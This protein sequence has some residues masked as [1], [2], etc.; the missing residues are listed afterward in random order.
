MVAYLAEVLPFMTLVDRGAVPSSLRSFV[1]ADGNGVWDT[2][3][4]TKALTRETAIRLRLR[5]TFQDYCHI[6]KAID[7]EHVRGLDGDADD[8]DADHIH[9]LRSTHTSSTADQIYGIDASML[10]DLTARTMNAFRAVS[11]RWHQFLH[12]NSRQ[13]G[14]EKSRGRGV[15]QSVSLPEPKRHRIVGKRDVES[16]VQLALERL[17]GRG[18]TYRSEEQKE[19]LLGIWRGDSPMAVV[20]PPSGGKSLLFQLP[21]SS[22]GARVTIVVLPFLAL[23]QNL[24]RRCDKLGI[25]CRRWTTAC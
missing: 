21:A 11:D 7:R 23:I 6:A 9:D 25:S 14:S 17:L 12:L 5:V 3:R 20:L 10:R 18:A 1:W 19:A 4:V 24:K 8:D 13:Q 2:P 22:P 16:E 15:S